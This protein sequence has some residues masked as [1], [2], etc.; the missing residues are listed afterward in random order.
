MPSHLPPG[1]RGLAV[2]CLVTALLAAAPAPAPAAATL[3]V[4]AR[5]VDDCEI[6]LPDLV[7]PHPRRSLPRQVRD[8]VVHHC[9]RP[10]QPQITARWSAWPPARHERTSAHRQ[11]QGGHGGILVTISY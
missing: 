6:R 1:S 3:T 9:R 11:R 8:M 5:V 2:A 7:P 10:V 4:R